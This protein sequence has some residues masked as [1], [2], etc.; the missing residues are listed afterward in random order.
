M[1]GES[2][3]TC[4][5]CGVELSESRMMEHLKTC[6]KIRARAS[7]PDGYQ[8]EFE[9]TGPSGATVL[10]MVNKALTYH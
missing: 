4:R 9:Y 2:S 7:R 1:D 8:I 6:Q 10:N 5:I 3:R